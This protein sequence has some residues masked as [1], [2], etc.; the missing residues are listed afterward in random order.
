MEQTRA[1]RVAAT[2]SWLRAHYPT[3]Y[4]VDVRWVPKLAHDP[5]EKHQ[6]SAHEQSMGIYANCD[7]IGRRFKILLSKR[8]CRTLAETT[9]TL[10]HEWAHALT[11][12]LEAQNNHRKSCH[13]DEYWIVFGRVYRHYYEGTGWSEVRNS[14]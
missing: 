3:A 5:T 11:W 14:C 2:T 1:Q 12:G 6:L 8:R 10:L 7:R 13:D 4:P 9:E